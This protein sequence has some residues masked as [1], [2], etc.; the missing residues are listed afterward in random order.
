MAKLVGMN[1]RTSTGSSWKK[2]FF[3]LTLSCVVI[4][5]GLMIKELIGYW[6]NES[7]IFFVWFTIFYSVFFAIGIWAL[8]G[9]F[10]DAWPVQK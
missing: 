7:P 4:R 1:K 6:P 10:N 8:V 5:F 9:L 3:F 2:A